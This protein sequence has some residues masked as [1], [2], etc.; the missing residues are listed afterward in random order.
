[1]E[2]NTQREKMIIPEYGRII[3]KMVE[4]CMQIQDRSKRNEYAK[5]IVIAMSQINPTGKETPHYLQ[6]LWDHLFIMSNYRLD[7][8]S[9][10]PKPKRE[11]KDEMPLPLHYKNSK[12]SFRPY[13]AILESMIDKVSLM[14]EGK[15][16]EEL[17]TTLAQE[18]KKAYLQWNINTCDDNLIREHFKQLSHGRMVL[19]EDFQFKTTKELIGKKPSTPTTNTKQPQQKKSKNKKR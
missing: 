18:L 6:K 9:P 8:D 1:M 16:K 13:G 12:I 19:S 17:K 14:P 2:Y 11:E 4:Y 7:V 10:Y 5:K 15:Q 3:Q